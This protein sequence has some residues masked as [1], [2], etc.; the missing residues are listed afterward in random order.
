VSQHAFDQL[1]IEQQQSVQAASAKFM[2]RFGDLGQAQDE[3]LLTTLFER[4]GLQRVPLSA[5]FLAEFRQSAR[6]AREE[7]VSEMLRKGGVDPT[8]L[9]RVLTWLADLRAD[10]TSERT[11]GGANH[12]IR[13][14][15]SSR[16]TGP[17]NLRQAPASQ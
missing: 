4:Q 5:D 10:E 6:R 9:S 15:P 1:G 11:P 8:L 16:A 14:S 17:E 2:V 7:T 3:A 13:S 12:G